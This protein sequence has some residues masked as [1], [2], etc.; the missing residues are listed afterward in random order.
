MSLC[1]ESLLFQ[2]LVLWPAEKPD[3]AQKDFP[4]SQFY[5]SKTAS[6]DGSMNRVY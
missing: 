2:F 4:F 5:F 1:K 6:I 3:G